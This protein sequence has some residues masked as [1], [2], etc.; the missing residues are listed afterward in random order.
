MV[1]TFVVGWI[2][3]SKKPLRLPT[4]FDGDETVFCIVNLEG[5]LVEL[6][7]FLNDDV[8][9]IDLQCLGKLFKLQR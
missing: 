5:V 3:N 9:S 6:V 8:L 2:E 1:V 4:N 7:A